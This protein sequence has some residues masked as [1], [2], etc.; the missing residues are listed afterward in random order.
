MCLSDIHGV[1]FPHLLSW[2]AF[3]AAFT[4][5]IS[6][7]VVGRGS[8]EIVVLLVFAHKKS[9]ERLL[10]HQHRIYFYGIRFYITERN[11]RRKVWIFRTRSFQQKY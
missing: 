7:N 8:N 10:R 2:S 3:A 5:Q 4:K 9:R 1:D 6:L 11:F